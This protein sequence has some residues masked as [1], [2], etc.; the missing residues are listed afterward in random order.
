MRPLIEVT[1]SIGRAVNFILFQIGWFAC[2]FSAAKGA[3][4]VGSLTVGGIITWHLLNVKQPNKEVFLLIAALVVGFI[5]E[6]LF[7]ATGWI[8]YHSNWFNSS[9]PPHWI[10]AMWVLFA[11]TLNVSLSWLKYRKLLG[12]LFGAIGGPLSFLAGARLG[13][14]TLLDSTYAIIALAIGW[15]VITPVLLTL[16]ARYDGIHP[17][18]SKPFSRNRN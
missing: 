2:V 18:T 7:I 10:L 12:I 9:F 3:P 15:A 16:A 5:W 6:T 14:V 4:W 17:V 11:T 8:T 1:S 13:A